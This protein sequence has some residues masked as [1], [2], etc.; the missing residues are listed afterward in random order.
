MEFDIPSPAPHGL[1]RAT[2]SR[3][4]LP[5]QWV[6][7][8]GIAQDP[9]AAAPGSRLKAALL[10]TNPGQQYWHECSQH[11]CAALCVDLPTTT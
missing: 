4:S 7:R 8:V 11:P 9:K 5:E 3:G 10:M 6:A 1:L 2:T